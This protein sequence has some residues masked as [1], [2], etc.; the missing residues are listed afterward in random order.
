MGFFIYSPVAKTRTYVEDPAMPAS[1]LD[2]LVDLL[3]DQKD[4]L[5]K[6]TC[7]TVDKSKLHLPGPDFVDRVWSASDR[8]P[9][10]LRSLQWIFDTG[11]LGGTGYLSILHTKNVL[12]RPRI[13]R[14]CADLYSIVFPIRDNPCNQ[15]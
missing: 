6:H 14:M 7:K 1:S 9:N 12:S 8:S 5:L 2:R 15:W 4:S 11:R 10:V 13:T 3:G